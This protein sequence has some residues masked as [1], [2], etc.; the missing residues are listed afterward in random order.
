MFE[1]LNETE[2]AKPGLTL[3]TPTFDIVELR[4]ETARGSPAHSPATAPPSLG[5]RVGWSSHQA[6]NVLL[7]LLRAARAR[8]RL[9]METHVRGQCRHGNGVG[10]A[11]LYP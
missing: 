8:P 3:Q 10:G 7:Y 5:S 1:Q 4:R 11:D 2:A 6:N 9:C